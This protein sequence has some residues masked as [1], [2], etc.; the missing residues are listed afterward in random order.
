[1]KG[2]KITVLLIGMLLVFGGLAF[3]GQVADCNNKGNMCK[4][5]EDTPDEFAKKKYDPDH[6][7]FR[8]YLKGNR[9]IKGVAMRRDSA[10]PKVIDVMFAT[11]LGCGKEPVTW[12]VAICGAAEEVG[13]RVWENN[14]WADKEV[15]I[16]KGKYSSS[17]CQ[18]F[19]LKTN[20]GYDALHAEVKNSQIRVH[21]EMN[22]KTEGYKM[23]V[24][25][26]VLDPQKEWFHFMIK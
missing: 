20:C 14:K 19:E 12:N 2:T 25:D 6:P 24:A 3:A 8:S 22:G 9:E 23:Y 11:D 5:T 16:S 10:N 21:V 4:M 26:K 17:Q 1:M 7:A 15:I 13:H 18:N